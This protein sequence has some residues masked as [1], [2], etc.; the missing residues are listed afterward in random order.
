[1]NLKAAK[2]QS[3]KVTHESQSTLPKDE[4]GDY[5]NVAPNE[6]DAKEY[7]VEQQSV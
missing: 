2:K 5:E 6:I 4:E 1:M 7:V 3:K